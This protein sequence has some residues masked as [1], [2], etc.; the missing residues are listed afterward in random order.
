MS[1]VLTYVTTVIMN[2]LTFISQS[3]EYR[4]NLKWAPTYSGLAIAFTSKNL[5]KECL[6]IIS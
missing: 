6:F 4:W 5:S 1:E 3:A 2:L